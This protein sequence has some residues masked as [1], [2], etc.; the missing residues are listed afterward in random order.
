L[1]VISLCTLSRGAKRSGGAWPGSPGLPASCRGSLFAI[2]PRYALRL[3]LLRF[4][5]L[6]R[7]PETHRTWLPHNALASGRRCLG[8]CRRRRW[9]LRNGCWPESRLGG[10]SWP[11][12]SS[13]LAQGP[14]TFWLPSYALLSCQK[15]ASLPKSTSKPSAGTGGQT[16][17]PAETRTLEADTPQGQTNA[18]LVARGMSARWCERP[19]IGGAPLSAAGPEGGDIAL[20]EGSRQSPWLAH[21]APEASPYAKEGPCSTPTYLPAGHQPG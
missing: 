1:P 3:L 16:P 8:R 15:Q 2:G 6:P 7:I 20:P 14:M 9:R 4:A 10:A 21:R 19:V 5:P 11:P 18:G 12:S 13:R 17:C